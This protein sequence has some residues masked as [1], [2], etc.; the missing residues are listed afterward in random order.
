MRWNEAKVLQIESNNTHK[1]YKESA[2]MSLVYHPISQLSLDVSPIWT[3]I[4]AAEVRK[5][6]FRPV[7]IM[8]ENCVF[9]LVQYKEHGTPEHGDRIQTP[10]CC[11]SNKKERWLMSRITIFVKIS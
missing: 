9:M 2:H 7:K 1:K 8:C 10:K 11:V 5:L 3:P 6:Q 4:I